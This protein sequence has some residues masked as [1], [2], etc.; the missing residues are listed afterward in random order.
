MSPRMVWLARIAILAAA[1]VP[2]TVRPNHT[3]AADPPPGIHGADMAVITNDP[4]S[5]RVVRT[6]E[7]THDKSDIEPPRNDHRAGTTGPGGRLLLADDS[8]PLMWLDPATDDSSGSRF[9]GRDSIPADSIASLRGWLVAPNYLGLLRNDIPAGVDLWTTIDSLGPGG[10]SAWVLLGSDHGIV[11]GDRLWKRH[12][13]QPLLRLD[14]RLVDRGVSFCRVVRLAS[15]AHATAGDRVGLWP[16][17]ATAREQRSRSAVC[18]VEESTSAALVWIAAPPDVPTADEPRV[19]FQRDGSYVGFGIVERRDARFWYVRTL[20]S[21]CVEPIR[22]GDDAIVRTSADVRDQSF[23]ARVFAHTSEGFQVTAGEPDGLQVG[24]I[25]LLLRRGTPLG[26]VEV[27]RVQGGYA[28][29]VRLTENKDAG[30]P[31]L[32]SEVE[33]PAARGHATLDEVR[34]GPR[35]DLVETVG[36]I[37]RMIG[38][39]L[40]VAELNVGGDGRAAG[41]WAVRQDGRI[42]GL[43]VVVDVT[44]ARGIGFIAPES[45]SGRPG[46]GAELVTTAVR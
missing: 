3:V 42:V 7:T 17:V 10:E 30:Q 6:H 8:G 19:E 34:F 18:F 43:A 45:V 5:V 40:F 24:Q 44:G 33:P 26:R 13:G 4:A 21:A 32:V 11:V 20:P 38:D 15:G 14:V 37:T 29:C 16:D 22:V 31:V 41:V 39:D 36:I 9:I 1:V 46:P 23:S 2:A 12:E 25:G 35:R 28:T 27:K